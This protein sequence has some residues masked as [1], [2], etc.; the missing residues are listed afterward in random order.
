MLVL[1]YLGA[2]V[3]AVA[4]GFFIYL[5][6]AL[7]HVLQFSSHVV[8][9]G[10]PPYGG[11]YTIYHYE[12]ARLGELRMWLSFILPNALILGTIC[13]FTNGWYA[14]HVASHLGA[15]VGTWAFALELRFVS[16]SFLIA[17][18]IEFSVLSDLRAL[19]QLTAV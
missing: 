10:T 14:Y 1:Y 8:S 11:I 12:S 18:V 6:I 17:V 5:F 9:V 7:L 16:I 13:Y 19:A 2:V 4:I 15:F 3:A